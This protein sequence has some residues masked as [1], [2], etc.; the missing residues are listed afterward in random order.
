MADLIIDNQYDFFKAVRVDEDGNLLI[1]NETLKYFS[2]DPV[3]DKLVA[4][5]A[6]ETTLSSIFLKEQHKISSGG[7]NV[8]FT[9]L[10]SDINWFPCW[11][12][13]TRDLNIK[14]SKREYSDLITFTE[15]DGANYVPFKEL[16]PSLG[17]VSV[18]GFSLKSGQVLEAGTKVTYKCFYY[19][20]LQTDSIDSVGFAE[21][22]GK[23]IYEDEITLESQ[24]NIGDEIYI[25]FSSP[26]EVHPDVII[27]DEI[28]IGESN[29]N[30]FLALESTSPNIF[31]QTIDF[32]TFEDV[33]IAGVK[34]L[35]NRYNNA[36][37]SENETIQSAIDNA[38]EGDKILCNGDFV[39]TED[40]L[41][42]KGIELD[43]TDGSTVGYDSYSSSN[44]NVFYQSDSSSTKDYTIRYVLI[45]N[46][47]NYGIYSKSSNSF[48][49]KDVDF[50]N[51]GQDGQTVYL[52]VEDNGGLLDYNSTQTE[53]QNNYNNSGYKG[54][55][56]RI[57]ESKHLIVD[58]C[59]QGEKGVNSKGS[60]RGFR[61][62]NCGK[63][64]GSVLV[65]NNIVCNTMEAPYYFASS[66][67][68]ELN[69]CENVTMY[70]NKAYDFG[71]CPLLPIGGEGIE[72][73]DNHFENGWNSEIGWSS[74]DLT[75]RNNTFKDIALSDYNAIGNIGDSHNS[76]SAIAGAGQ[77]STSSFILDANKNKFINSGISV[78]TQRIGFFMSSTVGS[79]LQ[80]PS[81]GI[82]S[83]IGNT[84][85]GHDLGFKIDANLNYI[86]FIEKDNIFINNGSIFEVNGAGQY[87]TNTIPYLPNA[88]INKDDTGSS[89][90]ISSGGYSIG[91]SYN[92]N[93]I[94][95]IQ[96]Q[97]KIRI[98]YKDSKIAIHDIDVN[99]CT[100]N[101]V[102]VNSVLSLAVS[103]LNLYISNLTGFSTGG[104]NPVSSIVANNET[105]EITVS[106]T[107]PATSFTINVTGFAVHSDNYI[108][109]INS[110]EGLN[111]ILDMSNGTTTTIDGSNIINGSAL[112]ANTVNWFIRNGSNS[113]EEV[114]VNHVDN[115]ISNNL[116]IYYGEALKTGKVFKFFMD[117]T[118]FYGNLSIGEWAG[119]TGNPSS[120]ADISYWIEKLKITGSGFIEYVGESS[121]SSTGL[122]LNNQFSTGYQ[123]PTPNATI[124]INYNSQDN[125]FYWYDS[126]DSLNP[127]FL[128]KSLISKDGLDKSI[129]MVGQTVS[130][131]TV[132]P[133][134]YNFDDTWTIVA[135]FDNSENGEWRDGIEQ[136]TIVKST[137]SIEKGEQF[138]LQFPAA[139]NNRW[140]G[141]GYTSSLTGESQ[142]VSY[143]SL[144]FRW[145]TT[146]I[147]QNA[148]D[149]TFNELND[150]WNGSVWD[151]NVSYGILYLKVKWLS[152]GII[153][154]HDATLNQEIMRTTNPHI[155]SELHYFFGANAYATS[156]SNIPSLTKQSLEEP[157]QPVVDVNPTVSNKVYTY[158][159]NSLF[160]ESF[161]VD[162]D[163]FI[164]N[165]W[166]SLNEPIW[167]NRLNMHSATALISGTTP[168][169]QGVESSG[170]NDV[171]IISCKAANS[172]GG[173]TTFDIN[174]EVSE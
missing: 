32:K 162:T 100:V 66:S 123:L 36:I 63:N 45:K 141:F 137:L 154:F 74:S 110:I 126:T 127:V 23:Q 81:K 21:N 97:D 142:P 164:A 122:D 2:Y 131:D 152:N 5:K 103:D 1:G 56:F 30:Y 44:G 167:F 54:G 134:I 155:A 149:W 116:P 138:V 88:D 129:N 6:I 143:L 104:G 145:H 82:V 49:L 153:T 86:T 169:N 89:I 140:T 75:V 28:L 31:A 10:S 171:Y 3:K 146:E 15:P 101:G 40:I 20:G 159:Q 48:N 125:K 119:A 76:S 70:N 25:D 35:K 114:S 47:G 144:G 16:Y 106:L 9:N 96:F 150:Y 12:G 85:N 18:F 84:F 165:D 42:T 22:L 94:E 14:G 62:Q 93:E 57:E 136:Q 34:D 26:L 78:A 29:D 7:E 4:T 151:Y 170:V 133:T 87:F 53:L 173:Y 50:E 43:F 115:Y 38:S 107:N 24:L 174:I 121:N 90:S 59:K 99:T 118:G 147:F 77:R 37:D 156:S 91:K 148:D 139:G 172:I 163:S 60:F 64:G 13:V 68:N 161:G 80:D 109:G 166:F 157:P 58:G 41:L 46:S 132:I 92:I 158:S 8:F 113:G 160:S 98:I 19:N 11:A 67:Y 69:G 102:Y 55:P 73:Y 52:G 108:T 51:C 112:I 130:S 71:N 135:D 83:L 79:T 95:A 33:N 105:N 124:E 128:G 72:V 168:P 17:S 27:Y 120:P 61:G 39:I 117:T 111:I 65:R